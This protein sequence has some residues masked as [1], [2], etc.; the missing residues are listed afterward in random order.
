M[1][2]TTSLEREAMEYLNDLK[3]SGVTNMY[4]ATPYLMEEMDLGRSDAGKIMRLWM[5][6]FQEDG[7][8]TT[9]K[10]ED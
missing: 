4:G 8:Y 3:D 9:V 2:K 5:R 7:D 1:R 6:N 10:K